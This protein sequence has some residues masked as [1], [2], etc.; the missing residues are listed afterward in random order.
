MT[1]RRIASALGCVAVLALQLC[2][3]WLDFLVALA[4]GPLTDTPRFRGQWVFDVHPI[5]ILMS[6]GM[7]VVGGWRMRHVWLIALVVGFIPP[8]LWL[9]GPALF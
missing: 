8:V 9:V 3:L 5:L 4:T 7:L 6:W 2:S 1:P